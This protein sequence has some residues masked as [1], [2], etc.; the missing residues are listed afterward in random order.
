MPYQN[1]GEAY[2]WKT[3]Y[4]QLHGKDS[5]QNIENALAAFQKA[6]S[7][8][9][10][11]ENLHYYKGWAY[12][13][14]GNNEYYSGQDWHASHE[15]TIQACLKAIEINPNNT[16]SYNTI[17][18]SFAVNAAWE[19]TCGNDPR[20]SARKAI[21]YARKAIS[22][23][24]NYANPY[25]NMATAY[26]AQALYELQHGMDPLDSIKQGN[27]AIQRANK[28]LGQARSLMDYDPLSAVEARWLMKQHRDPAAAFDHAIK[29][30]E[31]SI[32]YTPD[33]A[34][35]YLYTADV[36]R[37]KAE[38]KIS[39]NKSASSE[40]KQ[41]LTLIDK[42]VSI[43]PNLY[44]TF[45]LKGVFYLLKAKTE[46]DRTR[47]I[48]LLLEAKKLLE[49]ALSENRNIKAKYQ[50]SLDEVNQLLKNSYKYPLP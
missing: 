33:Y 8:R 14:K 37:W 19:M 46:N 1:I 36:Y 25:Y 47:R 48:K 31:S 45:A 3:A 22:M 9:P 40:I 7:I 29:E 34:E 27:Q 21:M 4:D 12:I 41:G 49:D 24:K 26:S 43:M 2:I 32:A 5:N 11:D 10:R 30:M 44:E 17:A 20:E 42:A 35:C 18:S 6:I 28:I 23:N 39:E 15:K 38:W 13:L 50:P 16:K